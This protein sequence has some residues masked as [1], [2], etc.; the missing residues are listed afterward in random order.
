MQNKDG[1]GEEPTNKGQDAK[2]ESDSEESRV[3]REVASSKVKILTS[4]SAAVFDD[5]EHGLHRAH[6]VN[7]RAQPFPN[8]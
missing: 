1:G 8:S 7:E 4:G 6:K 5:D 3:R 2:E